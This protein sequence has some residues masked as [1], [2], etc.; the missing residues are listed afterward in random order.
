MGYGGWEDEF[1]SAIKEV[2]AEFDSRPN[3]LWCVNE[4]QPKKELIDSLEAGVLRGRVCFYCGIDC[5]KALPAIL[6]NLRKSQEPKVYKD[7]WNKKIENI[8]S[9]ATNIPYFFHLN[10]LKEGIWI[11][12]SSHGARYK[13]YF[14]GIEQDPGS[15]KTPEIDQGP[16]P[17][18][19]KPLFEYETLL[20]DSKISDQCRSELAKYYPSPELG[21]LKTENSNNNEIQWHFRESESHNHTNYQDLRI[22]KKDSYELII[23]TPYDGTFHWC[24]AYLTNEETENP[25][26]NDW[27]KVWERKWVNKWSET[28]DEDQR[29]H[30][31]WIDSIRSTHLMQYSEQNE[32]G[33]NRAYEQQN[34]DEQ[35]MAENRIDRESICKQGTDPHE[36]VNA[37]YVAIHLIPWPEGEYKLNRTTATAGYWIKFA[38]HGRTYVVKLDEN[39]E[40]TEWSLFDVTRRMRGRWWIDDSNPGNTKLYI[41]LRNW[42]LEVEWSKLKQEMN[43]SSGNTG[44]NPIDAIEYE[45]GTDRRSHFMVAHLLP[46]LASP[47]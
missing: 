2:V 37:A 14:K 33:D 34:N 30:D 42:R 47:S 24:R 11:L 43:K 25:H 5:N 19:A 31:L 15:E 38:S 45:S 35:T 36:P 17:L 22:G 18:E 4:K 7:A 1:T 32:R 27:C 3:I 44:P 16:F 21:F 9:K 6:N 29:A 41:W 39:G 20:G 10:L 23:S 13:L 26:I 28:Q 46:C 12:I 40:L 8:K